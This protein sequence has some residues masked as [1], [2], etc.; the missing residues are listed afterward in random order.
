MLQIDLTGGGLKKSACN[1]VGILCRNF[2]SKQ[3]AFQQWV[4]GFE[5]KTGTRQTI[6]TSQLIRVVNITKGLQIQLV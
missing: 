2:P 3:F 5:N 4:N 6:T 1:C